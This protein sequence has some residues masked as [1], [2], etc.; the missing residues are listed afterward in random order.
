MNRNPLLN[1]IEQLIYKN[2]KYK[3]RYVSKEN[4]LLELA[5]K[6]IIEKYFNCNKD[7][8]NIF[9]NEYLEE[10]QYESVDFNKKNIEIIKY[11]LT[12]FIHKDCIY[13]NLLSCL[14]I[15][16]INKCFT[17]KL[18]EED[19]GH[20]NNH[21][22]WIFYKT[23]NTDE[24]REIISSCYSNYYKTNINNNTYNNIINCLRTGE[25]IQNIDNLVDYLKNVPV[26]IK[27]LRKIITKHINNIIE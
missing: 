25:E 14:T 6:N 22:D 3:S 10:K 24:L 16:D 17:I 20:Y 21:Y 13:N 8:F 26:I 19:T 5:F 12:Y 27:E 18:T 9:I 7:E 23:I 4:D 1:N 2:I 15:E 11:C